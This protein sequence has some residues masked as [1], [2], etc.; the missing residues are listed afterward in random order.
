[1]NSDDPAK[2]TVVLADVAEL[3]RLVTQPLYSVADKERM[4]EISKSTRQ[5][6]QADP[7]FSRKR[8]GD[9]IPTARSWRTI[10]SLFRMRC[11]R[12]C[13]GWELNGT[14]SGQAQ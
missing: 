5:P 9:F 10:I 1:M 4:L 7:S 14:G 12:T 13:G 8:D 6:A 11:G 3:Q 2:T